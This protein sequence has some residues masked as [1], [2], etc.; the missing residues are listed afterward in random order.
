MLDRIRIVMV[1][2]SHAGNIGSAARAMKTMGLS[3]LWLVDPV[4]YPKGRAKAEAMASGAVDVLDAARVVATLDEALAGCVLVMGASARSR[5]VPW[6]WLDA[7]RAATTLLDQSGAAGAD[8]AVLFGREASGLTNEELARCHFHT[9]IPANPEYPVLNVA[10]A[11]QVIAYELRKQWLDRGDAPPLPPEERDP[12]MLVERVRWDKPP[13]SADDLERFFGHLEQT[14][15][16]LRFFVLDD[17]R[18]LLVRLRRLYLRARPDEVEL[19][20]LRGVL[21]ATQRAVAAAGGERP[22][23]GE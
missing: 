14:L 2:T 7:G 12:G 5:T 6:P 11:I 15:L 19:R 10:S 1:N 17:P 3:S 22:A 20:I 23:K 21:A 18:Q 9:G 13:A 16:D 4:D 8:V